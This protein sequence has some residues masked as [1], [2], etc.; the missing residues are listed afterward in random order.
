MESD[1]VLTD[2]IKKIIKKWWVIAGLMII[3]GLTGMLVT[4]IHK[5]VYQSTAII[6]TAVDYAYAG[7]LED[8]ELDHILLAVGDIVDSTS[9]RQ[10]VLI[11]SQEQIHGL[12][13]DETQKSMIAVRK[14]Y[15]WILTARSSD[16]FVAQVLASA[17]AE[18]AMVALFKMNQ[19]ALEDFHTQTTL[20]S[21]ESCFSESVVV[22]NATADCSTEE[23]TRLM[24]NFESEDGGYSNLRESILLSNLSFQVTTK[25]TLPSAPILFRQNLNVAAGALIGLVLGLSWFFARDK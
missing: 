6:T 12:T 1:L 20:L 13:A 14:G 2:L 5:P 8:Y 15:D 10:Q 3:G 16:P 23:L 24:T 9:V 25:P 22:E 4:R 7:R 11:N 19:Q 18:N 17:W 21:I